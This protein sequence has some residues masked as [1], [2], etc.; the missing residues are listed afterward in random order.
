MSGPEVP[1]FIETEVYKGERNGLCLAAKLGCGGLVPSSQK[2]L[3]PKDLSPGQRDSGVL[4]VAR[5][6]AGR[7]ATADPPGAT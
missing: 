5:L 3:R 6:K 4:E 2:I 7:Q 1:L